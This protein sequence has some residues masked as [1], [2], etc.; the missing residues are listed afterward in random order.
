MKATTSKTPQG[1]DNSALGRFAAQTRIHLIA[2][3]GTSLLRLIQ[4]TLRWTYI[5]FE[6]ANATWASGSPSLVTFWHGRQLMMPWFYLK[7]RN[8]S[9]YRRMYVLISEHSDGRIIA[10]V[11]SLL[12]VGSI[13]GSS[14][15][16]GGKALLQLIR[17]VKDGNHVAVTPDGPRGP[18]YEAKPGIVLLAQRTQAPIRL[19]TI[20]AERYWTF[21]SWDGM[22][23]PKPF[24]RAVMIMAPEFT[25]P[26][27]LDPEG[28]E[29]HRLEIESALRQITDQ[30]DN[31]FG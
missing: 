30:A 10:Q 9:S 2:L 11:M 8:Q 29:K 19:V 27:E 16:G 26:G 25:V 4:L 3:L 31:Y 7:F 18:R 22:I 17:A 13:A 23:L 21:G 20:A 28:V 1:P 5:G 14:S 12:G 6:G 24:S 15:H